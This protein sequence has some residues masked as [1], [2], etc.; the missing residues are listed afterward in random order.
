MKSEPEPPFTYTTKVALETTTVR[1]TKSIP[2]CR[3][4]SRVTVLNPDHSYSLIMICDEDDEDASDKN[5][6]AIGLEFEQSQRSRSVPQWAAHYSPSKN[7]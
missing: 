4:W 2:T 3:F 7:E 5:T 1:S 6:D